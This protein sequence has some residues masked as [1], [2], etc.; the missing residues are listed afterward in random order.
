MAHTRLPA[1]RGIAAIVAM[2]FS[3]G[4]TIAEPDQTSAD[5]I[6]HGCRDA[7]SLITFTDAGESKEDLS[8]MSL[9][10]G[11]IIGVSYMGQPY[12][13]CLPSGANSQQAT[14]I[15][16]QYIDGQTGRMH[17][18]FNSL[19]IEALREAWPCWN[20]LRPEIFTGSGADP[21]RPRR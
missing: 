19:A 16:V 12:G 5:Y 6:M 3:C 18:N 15:V 2:I 20:L 21:L 13:I 17:E 11:L 7:A 1:L 9:C 8:R 10:M 4:I 14:R